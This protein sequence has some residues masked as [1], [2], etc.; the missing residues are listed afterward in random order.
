M[1]DEGPPP[2]G[3][4]QL[5]VGTLLCI[6]FYPYDVV[7]LVTVAKQVRDEL[8]LDAVFLSVA[9]DEVAAQVREQV[10]AEGF[11]LTKTNEDLP[12]QHILIFTKP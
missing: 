6:G 9:P 12:R 11:K 5:T 8:G 4:K 10:E 7:H 1:A 3:G 2:E